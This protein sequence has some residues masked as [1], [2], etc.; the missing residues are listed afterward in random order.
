MEEAAAAASEGEY[1]ACSYCA[2]SEAKCAIGFGLF[3]FM[4]MFMFGFIAI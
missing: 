4:F 1:P 3:P 2:A